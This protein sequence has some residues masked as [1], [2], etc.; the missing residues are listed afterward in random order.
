MMINV[1][2]HFIKAYE[3]LHLLAELYPELGNFYY[4][5]DRYLKYHALIN[6]RV[7]LN[8]G[9]DA[10]QLC[11]VAKRIGLSNIG[12]NFAYESTYLAKNQD[13]NQTSR[14]LQD[15]M[16]NTEQACILLANLAL[17]ISNNE[18]NPQTLIQLI[19]QI[20]NAELNDEFTEKNKQLLLELVEAQQL[21]LMQMPSPI[22]AIES[23]QAQVMV[24]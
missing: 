9:G 21:R 14:I 2:T 11:E 24:A 4:G 18:Q 23:P 7:F 16:D 22:S 8:N 17:L 15:V 3:Q 12:Y 13:V 19:G 10:A 5:A 20:Q 1:I 6:T